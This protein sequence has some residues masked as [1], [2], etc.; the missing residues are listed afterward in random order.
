[1]IVNFPVKIIRAR[2]SRVM[3]SD[4]PQG[5]STQ[6][7]RLFVPAAIILMSATF[8]VAQ[9][10]QM[11]L[12]QTP[13]PSGQVETPLEG[14]DVPAETVPAAVWKY[15]LLDIDDQDRVTGD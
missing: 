9:Q 15:Q 10:P 7:R 11:A 6:K 2:L 13:V 8:A 14:R 5:A 12:G 1:M 3:Q 4:T